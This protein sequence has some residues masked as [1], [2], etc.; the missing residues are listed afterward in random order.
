MG[1]ES[2]I[3]VPTS[4]AADVGTQTLKIGEYLCLMQ[5]QFGVL[6]LG[7]ES[8]EHVFHLTAGFIVC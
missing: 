6:G 3:R 7:I 4:V 5:G 2:H 1:D 8:K